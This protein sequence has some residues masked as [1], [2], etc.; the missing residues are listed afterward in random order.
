MTHPVR[1]PETCGTCHEDLDLT[2]KYD[3]LIDH[4]IEI[5]QTSVHG[6]ATRGGVYVAA[7]CNDCHST[8]G[9]AHRILAPGGYTSAKGR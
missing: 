3:I 1:L 8:G 9:S 7:T 2:T 6:K 5:Y 4:P